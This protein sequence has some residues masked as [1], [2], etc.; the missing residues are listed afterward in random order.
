M[1]GYFSHLPREA[2]FVDEGKEGGEGGVQ[3]E[4]RDVCVRIA[5]RKH[6]SGHRSHRPKGLG[7]RVRVKG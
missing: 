3:D 6:E 7:L 1:L 5:L 4:P 2:N